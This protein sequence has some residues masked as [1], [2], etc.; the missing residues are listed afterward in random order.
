MLSLFP[1]LLYLS[2]F[3][4]TTIRI[5]TGLVILYIGIDHFYKKDPMGVSDPK[6]VIISFIEIL[7]GALLLLGVF[8]QL[9]SII[10]ILY[11]I[12]AII[13]RKVGILPYLNKDYLIY[14]LLLGNNLSLLVLGPGLFSIDLPL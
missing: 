11:S 4:V 7:S 13:S 14:I 10:V 2:L 12:V 6:A 3:G 8:T 9:A 1:D 5:V